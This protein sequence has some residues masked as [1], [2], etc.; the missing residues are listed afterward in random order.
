MAE[1]VKAVNAVAQGAVLF[2]PKCVC[3]G[4]CAGD[5]VMEGLFKTKIRVSLDREQMALARVKRLKDF[6]F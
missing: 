3:G 4:I 6:L 5:P 1:N 2:D